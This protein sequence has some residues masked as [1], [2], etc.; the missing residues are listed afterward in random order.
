[1]FA[2]QDCV[3]DVA[4]ALAGVG[5]DLFRPGAASEEIAVERV[6]ERVV[7]RVKRGIL[8]GRQ[9]FLANVFEASAVE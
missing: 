8:V 7:R 6:D 1:L 9:N 5:S 3:D 4:S 2:V